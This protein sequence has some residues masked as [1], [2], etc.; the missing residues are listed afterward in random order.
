MTSEISDKSGIPQYDMLSVKFRGDK[1]VITLPYCEVANG[2]IESVEKDSDEITI[3]YNENGI[4]MTLS[5]FTKLMQDT[6][7]IK[8]IVELSIQKSGSANTI[9]I[10]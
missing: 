6:F 2:Y 8:D 3:I 7:D 10:L 1:E 4:K 9:T 5:A